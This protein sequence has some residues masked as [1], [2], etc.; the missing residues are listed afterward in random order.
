M[1]KSLLALAA[2]CIAT[3]ASAQSTDNITDYNRIGLSYNN[4]H[5]GFNK[6]YGEKHNDNN[7]SMNGIGLDYIHGCSLTQKF[8]L[9]LEIGAT[10]GASFRNES[11]EA[12][13]M[14]VNCKLKSKL[15]DFYLSVPV[16]ISYRFNIGNGMYINPYAGVTGK[17]HFAFR[18]REIAEINGEKEETDWM[19][20]FSHGT[21]D[22]NDLTWNRVQLGW[23]VGAGY[24]Y[25]SLYLGVQWGTDFI[26][27]YRHTFKYG[28]EETTYKVSTS[29]LKCTVAYTF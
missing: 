24:E 21:W 29:N 19:C 7:F 12:T 11:E 3:A 6:A 20:L 28:N 2:F 25:K 15:Q 4:T 26:G 10:L 13:Y 14:G 23:Q 17:V 1:K 8:P 18:Y 5:F 9:Y 22:S 27:A 16:N